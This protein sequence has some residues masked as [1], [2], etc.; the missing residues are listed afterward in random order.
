MI[1]KECNRFLAGPATH[2]GDV[3]E[4]VGRQPGVEPVGDRIRIGQHQ[5]R[6]SAQDRIGEALNDPGKLDLAISLK[7]E[8]G[9]LG[10]LLLGLGAPRGQ[11]FD[12][13][14]FEK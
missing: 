11:P 13:G 6:C 12:A 3:I 5:F 10:R 9:T 8:P 14:S 1:A 7:A 2:R 4:A